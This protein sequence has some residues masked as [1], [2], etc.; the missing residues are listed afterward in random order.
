MELRRV[1]ETVRHRLHRLT[2]QDV[3]DSYKQISSQVFR[4]TVK[5]AKQT[6]QP[7]VDQ[8]HTN[9][10]LWIVPPT[11]TITKKKT[12]KQSKRRQRS[13]K[14][15]KVAKLQFQCH[16][17]SDKDDKDHDTHHNNHTS[18]IL[19]FQDEPCHTMSLCQVVTRYSA[20]EEFYQTTVSMHPYL[21]MSIPNHTDYFHHHHHNNNNKAALLT[22]VDSMAY[23]QSDAIWEAFLNKASYA[24]LS[25]RPLYIWIGTIDPMELQ[26][27]HV[28]TV[29]NAFGVT[30]NPLDR[31]TINYLKPIAFSA[32]LTKQPTRTNRISKLFFLDAD[33]YFNKE[34]FVN[35]TTQQRSTATT[36]TTRTA[37]LEDWF[38]LSP[39]ASLL[40]SQNPSGK[41]ENILLN[42]GFLGLRNTSWTLDFAALWWFLRCGERDQI[43]KS[44]LE[45][46]HIVIPRCLLL[47]SIHAYIQLNLNL[48]G[49]RSVVHTLYYI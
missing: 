9:C 43:G 16:L 30:C 24:M 23:L 40:G 38:D 46:T 25:Q 12:T 21:N 29:S 18:S 5:Q 41:K 19:Q 2:E 34:A 33:I 27:R 45:H 42:G 6:I 4:D 11:S 36:T 35:L 10:R 15:K 47:Q 32:L 14:K 31:N 7:L 37:Q 1:Y 3:M 13:N 49:A 8:V 20:W 28:E 26:R 48:H 22:L 39:Q 17:G 44:F